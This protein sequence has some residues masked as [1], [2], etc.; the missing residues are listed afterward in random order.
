[1]GFFHPMKKQSQQQGVCDREEL[2]PA[3]PADVLQQAAW[4]DSSTCTDPNALTTACSTPATLR[5][6]PCM[7]RDW[8]LGTKGN[9]LW[10]ICKKPRAETTPG[11]QQTQKSTRRRCRAA[12]PNP[13]APRAMRPWGTIQEEQNTPPVCCTDHSC[14]HYADLHLCSAIAH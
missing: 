13:G 5:L 12:K 2:K 4:G 9:Q 6:P 10:E 11:C 14:A 3:V 1:M 8:T 7:P